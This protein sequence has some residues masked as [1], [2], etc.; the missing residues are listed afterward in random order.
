MLEMFCKMQQKENSSLKEEK[1]I[2]TR[3]VCR[4]SKK[5]TVGKDGLDFTRKRKLFRVFMY[6]K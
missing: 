3:A 5:K 2:R 4:K 1:D 6:R